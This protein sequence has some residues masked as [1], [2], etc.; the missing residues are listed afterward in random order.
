MSA[1][2]IKLPDE[3]KKRVA[4]LAASTGRT[5]H[6]F[7]VEAIAREAERSELRAR[8]AR[9]ADDSERE[10][11]TSGKAYPLD[12]AFD[13]LADKVAGRQVRRPRARAWRGSK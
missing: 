4:K 5:P 13:Y 7:M 6:A 11:M 8:F 2:S 1:T 3:L 12:V 10:T 9:E